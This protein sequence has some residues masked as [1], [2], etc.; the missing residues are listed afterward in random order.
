VVQFDGACVD[1]LGWD[2]EISVVCELDE[3]VVGV[4]RIEVGGYDAGL[5]LEP[6]TILADIDIV[7]DTWNEIQ[8]CKARNT[9]RILFFI[10]I[11]HNGSNK[12]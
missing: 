9:A 12:T 7:D 1:T 2:D 3:L 6:C 5:R 4:G 11:H 10:F 8:S